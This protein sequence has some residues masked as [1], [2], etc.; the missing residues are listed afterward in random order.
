VD[1]LLGHQIVDGLHV[2]TEGYEAGDGSSELASHS[3]R[4]RRS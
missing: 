4:P 1:S 3:R 2:R